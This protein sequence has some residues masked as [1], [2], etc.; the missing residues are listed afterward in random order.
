[1]DMT[2]AAL[3]RGFERIIVVAFGGLSIYLG[4]LLF[5]HMPERVDSQ[6]K[7]VLPGGISIFLSRVGPGTF[8]SLFGAIVLAASFYFPVKVEQRI[9]VGTMTRVSGFSRP[10]DESADF[11]PVLQQPAPEV[12]AQARV[13][14]HSHIAFLN[15]LPGILKSDLTTLEQ[16]DLMNQIKR[17]KLFVLFKDTVWGDWGDRGKFKHWVKSGARGDPP[18]GF[19]EAADLYR[20][21]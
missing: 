7:V 11:K 1:M 17:L 6:G 10:A 18:D 8:F 12:V 21:E 3:M 15:R 16:E 9:S 20:A 13:E 5:R 19:R 4:Y 14:A 2:D